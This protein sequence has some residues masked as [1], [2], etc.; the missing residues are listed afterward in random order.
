MD[1]AL[2][3]SL[4]DHEGFERSVDDLIRERAYTVLLF[5]VSEW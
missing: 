2:R 4:P 3:I 5:Y 1:N